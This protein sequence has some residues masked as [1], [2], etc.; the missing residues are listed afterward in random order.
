M[1]CSHFIKLLYISGW[2]PAHDAQYHRI[3]R[4]WEQ[5]DKENKLLISDCERLREELDICNNVIR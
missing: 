5:I 2:E 4:M 3:H 1:T